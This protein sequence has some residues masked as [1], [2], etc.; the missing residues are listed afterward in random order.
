M[1]AFLPH[2]LPTLSSC[3]GMVENSNFTIMMSDDDVTT[4]FSPQVFSGVEKEAS[5]TILCKVPTPF[6]DWIQNS[7]FTKKIIATSMQNM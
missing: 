3:G 2:T 4:L 7:T 1:I 6:E 5:L